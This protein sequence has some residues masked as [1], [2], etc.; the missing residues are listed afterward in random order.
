MLLHACTIHIRI[1]YYFIIKKI[2]RSLPT[3]IIGKTAENLREIPSR[4]VFDDQTFEANANRKGP[5][6]DSV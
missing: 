1:R 3:R 2:P 4:S 5:Q 6:F